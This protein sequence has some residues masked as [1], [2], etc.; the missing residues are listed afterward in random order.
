MLENGE[1]TVESGANPDSWAASTLL[2]ITR[3]KLSIR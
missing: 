2:I 3:M 1:I